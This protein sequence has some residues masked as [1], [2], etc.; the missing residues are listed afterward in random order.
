MYC[1]TLLAIFEDDLAIRKDNHDGGKN[2]YHK[3]LE[4]KQVKMGFVKKCIV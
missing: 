2:Q 4:K 1:F 3:Q